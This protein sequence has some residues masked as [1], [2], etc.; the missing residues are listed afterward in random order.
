MHAALMADDERAP[1]LTYS[2]RKRVAVQLGVA[3]VASIWGA[4]GTA[5]PSEDW[6]ATNVLGAALL[7]LFWFGPMAVVLALPPVSRGASVGLSVLV[8]LTA[9]ATWVEFASTDSSTAGLIFAWGWVAGVP[10]AAAVA[11]L[12]AWRVSARGGGG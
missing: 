10:L 12:C 6:P 1:A 2:F 8:A 11:G 5:S 3:V 9:W 4:L 7:G